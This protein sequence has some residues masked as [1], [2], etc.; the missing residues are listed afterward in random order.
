MSASIMRAADAGRPSY[1]VVFKAASE[2]NEKSLIQTLGLKRSRAST[3]AKGIRLLSSRREGGPHT[4]IFARLGAA[5]VDLDDAEIKQLEARDDVAGIYANE[6]RSIPKPVSSRSQDQTPLTDD[7]LIAYLRGM[8]DAVEL[9]LRYAEEGRG[10]EISSTGFGPRR[11]P[12]EISSGLTWGLSAIGMPAAGSPYTGK[13]VKLAVLDTGIDLK[14]PDL[15]GRVIEGSTAVSFV[16]GESVQDGNGHGT[17]CAGLCGGPARPAAGPRYGVAPDVDLLIGKVL[18]NSGSGWDDGILEGMEWA[19]DQGARVIS[20]SLGSSRGVNTPFRVPYE[21]IAKVLFDDAG[22]ALVIAAAGNDSDRPYSVS[23]VNN[24]AAAPSTM[25]VAA[26]DERRDVAYFS[27][28]ELD[29][30]G[31]LDISGPGVDIRSSWPGGGY[32]SIS[33]TSMATP[34]VAGTAALWLEANPGLT[35]RQLWDRLISSSI[36]LGPHRDFGE[37]LVQI[38]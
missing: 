6:L 18:D 15:E 21:N 13:G 28:A 31:T 33:G 32:K 30:I 20:M 25:A 12:V 3:L 16:D 17:H 10:G 36:H 23:P 9:A 14:H 38:P 35:P 22:G 11:R 27:C 29:R 24:P 34:I 8:R 2:E 26:I 5:A 37:G 1:I 19:I 7:P 4:K